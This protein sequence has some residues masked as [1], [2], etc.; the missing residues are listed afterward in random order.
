MWRNSY[1]PGQDVDVEQVMDA[2]D[3]DRDEGNEN[4]E[5]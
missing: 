3:V 4:D 2:L 1:I 5:E